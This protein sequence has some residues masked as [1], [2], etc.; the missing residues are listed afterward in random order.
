MPVPRAGPGPISPPA[1]TDFTIIFTGLEP[2]ETYG[3]AMY[4]EIDDYNPGD[5]IFA[6]DGTPHSGQDTVKVYEASGNF[7]NITFANKQGLV[8][9]TYSGDSTID[10]LRCLNHQHRIAATAT[11][12]L[13]LWGASGNNVLK[14]N[15]ATNLNESLNGTGGDNTFYAAGGGTYPTHLY[16]YDG[17]ST[18]IMPSTGNIYIGGEADVSNTLDFSAL[19]NAVTVDLGSTSLQSVATGLTVML[20]SSTTITNAVGGSDND[21]IT[22]NSLANSISGGAGNDTLYG[23]DGADVLDGGDGTDT[24]PART[25]GTFE[26]IGKLAHC[27]LLM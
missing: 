21:T 14:A 4:L 27:C 7:E 10:N 15:A 22:G 5:Q 11:Y 19:S 23:L 9:E 6:V 13:V 18:Y 26:R 3:S 16:G 17:N 8:I 2:V 24:G 20:A 1:T 25:L 12:G